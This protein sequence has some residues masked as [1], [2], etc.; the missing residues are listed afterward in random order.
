MSL[1]SFQRILAALTI[2]L[3]AS[4]ASAQVSVGGIGVGGAPSGGA[5]VGGGAIGSGVGPAA[6]AGGV[7]GAASGVV[8]QGV[9][10]AANA[11]GNAAGNATTQPGNAAANAAG[12][13][14]GQVRRL[15]WRLFPFDPA[16]LFRVHQ[17][18]RR[19]RFHGSAACLARPGRRVAPQFGSPADPRRRSRELFFL[20]SC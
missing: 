13:A 5:G 17:R 6:G 7:T 16:R 18:R 19:G 10:G 20:I 14:S 15:S 8:N 4:I 1:S 2:M 9:Q 12:A 3:G 11:A